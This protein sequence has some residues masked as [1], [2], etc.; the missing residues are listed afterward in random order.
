MP[1]LM[2]ILPMLLQFIIMAMGD[3]RNGE[4]IKASSFWQKHNCRTEVPPPS[5]VQK[6]VSEVIAS[7]SYIK[8]RRLH[9]RNIIEF[10]LT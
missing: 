9:L 8:Q 3:E 7:M 4:C 5:Y 1:H 6:R 2:H 10:R